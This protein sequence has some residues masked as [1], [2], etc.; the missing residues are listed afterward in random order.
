MKRFEWNW[1]LD[2]PPINLHNVDLLQWRLP[3]RKHYPRKATSVT[4]RSQEGQP[5][6]LKLYEL[7]RTYG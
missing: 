2:I 7:R 4:V 3:P 6:T 1:M 5:N